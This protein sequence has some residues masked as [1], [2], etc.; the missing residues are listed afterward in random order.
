M[1]YTETIEIDLPRARVIELFDDPDSMKQWQPGLIS[2]EHE[3]GEPG[4]EGA[5][6]RLRYLMGKRECEMVETITRRALPEE[7]S[8]TYEAPGMWNEVRN[9]FEELGPGRTRWTCHSEFRGQNLLMKA[10]CLL[11]PGAFRKETRKHLESFKAF[12]EGA[13]APAPE[14]A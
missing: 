9:H 2:F 14:G 12:A 3:S 6:S 11:M 4:Q 7:F 5:R 8:G 13:G 1:K 10:L